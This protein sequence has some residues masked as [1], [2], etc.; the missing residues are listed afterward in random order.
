MISSIINENQEIFQHKEIN[1]NR[2]KSICK[3]GLI[4]QYD[5]CDLQHGLNAN[6]RKI[7][8]QKFDI[9]QKIYEKLRAEIMDYQN[10]LSYDWNEMDP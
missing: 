6:G 2:H 1:I 9:K 8:R 10:D 5:D 4:C 7:V 3:Y